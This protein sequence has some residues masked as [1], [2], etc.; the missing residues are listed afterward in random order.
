[1]ISHFYFMP[2][3][4]KPILLTNKTAAKP[5]L[6][7]HTKEN[8][9]FAQSIHFC[10]F[11][12]CIDASPCSWFLQKALLR[13]ILTRCTLSGA[14]FVSALNVAG[15]LV[16]KRFNYFAT[17]F[18]FSSLITLSIHPCQMVTAR[19]RQGIVFVLFF[20]ST[21]FFLSF[22]FVLYYSWHIMQK[23]P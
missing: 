19:A 10:F 13:C 11:G 1:M 21:K 5:L 17:L 14:V 6:A 22:C 2:A 3:I 23:T 9:D 18:F 15:W 16:L 20:Y 12:I 8:M 7:M 4:Y